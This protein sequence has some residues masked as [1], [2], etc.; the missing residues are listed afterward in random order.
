MWKIRLHVLR[1]KRKSICARALTFFSL[2][3]PVA[4]ESERKEEKTIFYI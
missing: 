1:E 4:E 2:H 3:P